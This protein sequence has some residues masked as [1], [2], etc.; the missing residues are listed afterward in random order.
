MKPHIQKLPLS[1]QSS[2]VADTF[3]TP[4][5]ETPWHYHAEYELVLIIQGKGK[6]FIGNHVADYEAGDLTFLGPNLPHLFRKEEAQAAGGS[7]VIHFKEEFIG[8][9][10]SQIPEMQKI[11]LLFQKSR[12]GL[13][14]N[15]HTRQVVTDKMHQMLALQGMERLIC[16]LHTL[17]VLANSAEY[18]LLSSPEIIGQNGNDSDRLDKVF[19]YVMAN[20]K[21]EIQL[22]EV[23]EIANMSY[24]GFCRYFKN[25]TKKN[26]SHFVNE[27]RIGYACKR[28][29]ESESSISNICF[30]SGYN[31]M[32]NFNEQFKKIVKCTPYQFQLKSKL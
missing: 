1:E 2:F 6:R 21:E 22:E 15:G 18:E 28:L 31:N 29:M 23:A 13:Q 11:R 5:F 20:F 30:E 26:F 12:M 9:E 32:T 3:I 24:S 10:F 8:R 17:S 27:I 19:N 7:L 25:R 16:L 4:Y 14:I